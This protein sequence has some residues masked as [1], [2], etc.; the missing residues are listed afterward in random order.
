MRF[1][2]E[3]WGLHRVVDDVE[4]VAGE[5]VA[6]AVRSAPGR[7][8]RVRLT[9]ETGAVVLA[10]W[11]SSPEMPV[12]RPLNDIVPDERALDPGYED[13]GRGLHIVLAL[14]SRCGVAVGQPSGKWVWARLPC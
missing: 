4:L 5:L 11:D 13:G 2:L 8:I 14:A 1:R 3:G 12:M 9:R 6:N 7:D 10:V